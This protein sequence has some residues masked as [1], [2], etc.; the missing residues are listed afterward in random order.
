MLGGTNGI[1]WSGAAGGVGR[2]AQG[3]RS[4]WI[5]NGRLQNV[6][7]SEQLAR[8]ISHRILIHLHSAP[9]WRATR[10]C[11][12]INAFQPEIK[13]AKRETDAPRVPY[14][15]KRWRITFVDEP[16]NFVRRGISNNIYI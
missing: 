10:L 7:T 15:V 4:A 12:L 16:K 11:V 2:A 1:L 6:V 8:F 9:F 14:Y 13:S 5:N 3:G